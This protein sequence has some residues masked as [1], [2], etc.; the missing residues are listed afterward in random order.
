MAHLLK[1]NFTHRRRRRRF[2]I[3]YFPRTLKH[4]S[5]FFSAKFFYTD[6]LNLR[7]TVFLKRLVLLFRSSE[8]FN[9]EKCLHKSV[10]F[11]R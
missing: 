11:F 3:R 10:Q 6:F 5:Q 7:F 1:N 9:H 8:F 4:G 2:K